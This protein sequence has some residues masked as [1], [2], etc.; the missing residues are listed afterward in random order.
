MQ[1]PFARQLMAVAGLAAFAALGA[2]ASSRNLDQ[3]FQDLSGNAELKGV[4]FADRTHDYGDIDITLYEG[5]LMLTGTM[6]TEAGHASLIKN[7][8]KAEN[9]S[10][11]IDEVLVA[12]GTSFGQGFE[13]TR[14][15][16]VLR[17][18]LVAAGDVS[19]TEYKIAVSN[20]VVYLI[21]IARSQAELDKALD[22]ARS[23][24]GV[25][26]VVTHVKLRGPAAQMAPVQ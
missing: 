5:R 15:D 14:I 8:W 19:S 22:L 3:S 2:C 26:K 12:E 24:A 16:Q 7:A 10:E 11:V 9:V 13:D 17:A 25:E 6:K 1:I 23:V 18:R 4:L 21:G 20:A